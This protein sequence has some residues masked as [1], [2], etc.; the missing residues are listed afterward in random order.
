MNAPLLAN[1]PARAAP[2][3]GKAF[4]D[5]AIG[6][7]APPQGDEKVCFTFQNIV[8]QEGGQRLLHVAAGYIGPEGG[9][10]AVL[11]LPLGINLVPGIALQIDQAEAWRLAAE[12]CLPDGCKFGLV[13]DKDRLWTFKAGNGGRVVFQDGGGRNINVPFSLKGF[14]AAFESLK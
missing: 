9:P 4:D 12:R 5:W 8:L 1:A 6:C 13:L 10:I 2:E 3:E 7:E 11:T 14:T